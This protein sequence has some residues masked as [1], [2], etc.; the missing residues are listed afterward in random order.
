MIKKVKVKQ[1]YNKKQIY[2]KNK[3]LNNNK[4]KE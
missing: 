4:K 2:K 1:K 3:H